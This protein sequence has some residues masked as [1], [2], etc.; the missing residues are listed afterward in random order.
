M[1]SLIGEQEPVFF[2]WADVTDPSPP[3]TYTLQVASDET[4][5]G[6]SMI[7]EKDGLTRSEYTLTAIEKQALVPPLVAG[8]EEE[9]APAAVYYWKVKA[10][11]GASNVSNWSGIGSFRIPPP[12][13]PEPVPTGMANW[14]LYTIFGFVALLIGI[15]G[16][17]LGR[18]TTYY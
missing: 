16:Y 11:D 15:L 6:A 3:V 9:P 4:F 13:P 2:D 12:I 10:T 17:W 1:N 14:I 5:S 18:R 8:D 7:L